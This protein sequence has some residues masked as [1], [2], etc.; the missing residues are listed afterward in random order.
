MRALLVLLLATL[1]LAKFGRSQEEAGNAVLREVYQELQSEE[2]DES[3]TTNFKQ[4]QIAIAPV[5]TDCKNKKV[6]HLYP[7]DCFNGDA[8]SRVSHLK[9]LIFAAMSK[10]R[11]GVPG[12]LSAFFGPEWYFRRQTSPFSKQ[13]MTEIVDDLKE[14]SAANPTLLLAP[15]TIFWGIQDGKEWLIFNCAPI[16]FGGRLLTFHCKSG[17]DDHLS[18]DEVWAA[19]DK[20]EPA[21]NERASCRK[22]DKKLFW[23]GDL[24]V[25]VDIC[26]D[27]TSNPVCF[28]KAVPAGQTIDVLLLLAASMHFHPDKSKITRGGMVIRCDGAQASPEQGAQVLLTR[29]SG[30]CSPRAIFDESTNPLFSDFVDCSSHFQLGK[31]C[32]DK[33]TVLADLL[34]VWL[35][36]PLLKRVAPRNDDTNQLQPS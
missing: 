32:V 16:L 14:L 6:S 17:E 31:S 2:E 30:S 25:G 13:E 1:A 22:L 34:Y 29:A 15:G 24:S 26:L 3:R 7:S 28:S 19:N 33:P 36:I 35:D 8:K 5:Y 27:H 4:I 11:S 10:F 9:G 20:S 12:L 23:V 21:K 18:Y